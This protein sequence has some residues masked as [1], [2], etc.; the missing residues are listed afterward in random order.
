MVMAAYNRSVPTAVAGLMPNHSRIG[1]INEPPPTPVMPTIKPT[2]SPAMIRPKFASSI[3]TSRK[4]TGKNLVRSIAIFHITTYIDAVYRYA[5]ARQT[6]AFVGA[7]LL[8]NGGLSVSNDVADTALSRAGS[9]P[10]GKEVYS[11]R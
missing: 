5:F 3:K 8:A 1:V 11:P 10:Q 6:E 9:L 4:T 7:S 2:T